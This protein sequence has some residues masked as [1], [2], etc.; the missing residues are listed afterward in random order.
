MRRRDFLK[1]TAAGGAVAL[2]PRT[3]RRAKAS[4]LRYEGPFWI[5]VHANGGWDPTLF[6][7]P[8][9]GVS[10]NR[11]TINQTFTRDEIQKVGAFAAAPVSLTTPGTGDEP[12]IE[13][14]SPQR[15][16]EKHG[17]RVVVFNG[18]DTSTNNH[19]T[20]TRLVWSGQ[21]G[22]GY[23]NVGA[24]AAANVFR[25][26]PVPMAFLSY[27]GYD[28]TGGSVPLT[29]A[30][31]VDD[32]WRV[33][34][35]NRIDPKKPEGAVYFTDETSER[36]KKAQEARIARL[37]G[38]EPL[39]VHRRQLA[40]L[41]STRQGDAGL[42]L[43]ADYLPTKLVSYDDFDDLALIP[44]NQRYRLGSL[45]NLMRQ[46]QMALAT[47]QAGVAVSASLN[48]GGYDTHNDHDSQHVPRL[49]Q[50]VR[51]VDYIFDQIDALGMRDQVYVV[52]AS[53]FGRTPNYNA[54]NGKDHWSVTSMVVAGPG[55][56]GGRV[57]G[58]T[59]DAQKP[60]TIDPQSLA[61]NTSG[62]RLRPEHVHQALRVHAGLDKTPLG[63]KFPLLT[64]TLPLLNG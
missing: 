45:E 22:E 64:Q 52:L 42:S 3:I 26:K 33:A 20:G 50:V 54:Q 53:D 61:T 63:Q 2:A 38:K 7:D 51:G 5:T 24:L 40:T 41:L 31:N 48:I 39:P 55:I 8:K 10:G 47:F 35:P 60:L 32:L 19:E 29:R 27:G 28:F 49:M 36:I 11:D 44:S 57:V 9:G 37:Q 25:D 13:V 62:I 16:F 23:P 15:F 59:D 18:V 21:S 58:G 6:C 43:L 30:G 12:G 1:L 14:M 46:A 56:E 4:S 34:F 17:R